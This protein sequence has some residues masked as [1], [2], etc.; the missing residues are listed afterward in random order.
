VAAGLL[1]VDARSH[2]GIVDAARHPGRLMAI[3]VTD[4]D[5]FVSSA[6]SESLGSEIGPPGASRRDAVDPYVGAAYVAAATT[7]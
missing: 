3:H 7:P 6:Q 5:G 1:R 4:L 2:R